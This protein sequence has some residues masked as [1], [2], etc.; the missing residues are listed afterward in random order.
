[1]RPAAVV[2]A[3]LFALGVLMAYFI[4]LGGTLQHSSNLFNFSTFPPADL[5]ARIAVWLV[6]L[7][8]LATAGACTLLILHW[9]ERLRSFLGLSLDDPWVRAGLHFVLGLAFLDLFWMGTGLNLIWSGAFLKACFA[10]LFLEA[11]A[12]RGLTLWR[13]GIP[14][15]Q[16][17]LPGWRD[18]LR[19][20]VL[21]GLGYWLFALAQ[22]LAP[23]TF[24][25]S[26]V[27]H[28]AVPAGW[29]A[30][31]GI[32][33]LSANFF[34]NYPYGG[35][36]AFLNGFFLQGTEAAKLLHAIAYLFVALF[37]G[38]WARRLGGDKS[39]WLTF[40]LVLTLPLYSINVATTQVEGLLALALLPAAYLS[41]EGAGRRT[42]PFT[43]ALLFAFAL[44]IKYTAVL[45]LL[46]T[47]LVVGWMGKGRRDWRVFAPALAVMGLLFL[48][49]WALKSWC[50]T[51]NPFH[52]YFADWFHGRQLDPA[53]YANLLTEQRGRIAHGWGLLALPWTMVMS[54]PNAFNFGGPMALAFLPLALLFM[55][56][57]TTVR[58][59]ALL[60]PVFL[61]GGAFVTHILR[62][63][64]TGL[65]LLY[66]LIGSVLGSGER[67]QWGKALA[68]SGVVVGL[69]CSIFLVAISVRYSDCAGIWTGRQ[70]RASYLAAPNKLT[71]YQRM[72]AWIGANT[73]KDAG[74]LIVGDGRGL[75]YDRPLMANSVFDEPELVR[76]ARTEK[77][78]AGIRRRL[79]EQGVDYL[80]VNAAE[81]IR[82]QPNYHLYQLSSQE[83]MRLDD[84]IQSY[85]QLVYMA[86]M[87]GVYRLL[88]A[89]QA[90]PQPPTLDLL[91]FL[92]D[93]A[94]RFV[95]SVQRSL[96]RDAQEALDR[97]L[98][99][100]PGNPFWRD[101][102]RQFEKA[103]APAPKGVG[104]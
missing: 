3:G 52:P 62:F 46:A 90:P 103:L 78:P 47:V 85:A 57:Q 61:V 9:G 74:L 89:S 87:R 86:D 14:R 65:I 19:S 7:Q 100:Y 27:Y 59:L 35:E 41:I 71:S 13:E 95:M 18:G 43:A 75:Y 16:R 69:F 2:G 37:A 92:S 33:D 44:S 55:S 28:L 24:Y 96:W 80:A 97:T 101:Q 25:D 6:S 48:L 60:G 102:K 10:V 20:F 73:P 17:P 45:G 88:P 12:S 63:L 21:V 5:S 23:E 83:W 50:F 49:P 68:W 72:A 22:G 38:G 66:I 82:V 30:H 79:R 29:L 76:L 56:R 4:L 42:S 26:M 8:A 31:H 39:A 15:L 104:R 99:L 84:F 77:D 58:A 11:L 36:L 93:P 32:V 64:G 91:L 34:S 94:S 51:G 53:R 81:G 70:D 54:N 40:A 98:E 1:M 67:P